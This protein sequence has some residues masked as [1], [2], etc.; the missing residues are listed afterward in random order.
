MLPF[1]VILFSEYHEEPDGPFPAGGADVM[2]TLDGQRISDAHADVSRNCI[3]AL[4]GFA[5][6]V[7]DS[8]IYVRFLV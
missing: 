3:L 1:S 4:Y 5:G 8:G 6:A 2:H 7:N